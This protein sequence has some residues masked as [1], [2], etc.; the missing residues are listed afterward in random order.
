MF[1][2]LA[3]SELDFFTP[4]AA[5]TKECLPYDASLIQRSASPTLS[6]LRRFKQQRQLTHTRQG[7]YGP[8]KRWQL[9]Q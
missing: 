7:A 3:A 9:D 1:D 8:M 4:A 2:K 6:G 5:M